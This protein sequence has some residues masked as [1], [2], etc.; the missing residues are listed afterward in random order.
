MLSENKEV[1]R[2]RYAVVREKIRAHYGHGHDTSVTRDVETLNKAMRDHLSAKTD[3]DLANTDE[4]M[5]NLIGTWSRMSKI[6]RDMD[7]RY[8]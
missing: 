3:F 1:H 8:A 6:M 7:E 2:V 5:I 4:T